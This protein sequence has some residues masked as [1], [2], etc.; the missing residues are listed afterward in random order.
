[1]ELRLGSAL[2]VVRQGQ[3]AVVLRVA[4]GRWWLVWCW[5]ARFGLAH[6]DL[7]VRMPLSRELCRCVCCMAGKPSCGLAWAYRMAKTVYRSV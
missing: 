2:P 4:R 6:E 1:M 5:W 7:S 3:L